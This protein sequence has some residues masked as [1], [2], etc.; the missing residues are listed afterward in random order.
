M[1]SVNRPIYTD[2]A[3]VEAFIRS[4]ANKVQH[5]FLTVA[6]PKDAVM[7]AGGP[8]SSKDTLGH[9][10]IKIKEGS[11]RFN[12]VITFTHN[13]HDYSVSENGVLTKR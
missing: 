8:D 3:H 2:K 1:N 13:N 6:M 9:P 5:A 7:K 11:L 10:L 4:K 12:R